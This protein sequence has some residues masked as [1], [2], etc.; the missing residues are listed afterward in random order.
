[1]H[2]TIPNFVLCCTANTLK[3]AFQKSLLLAISS[4]LYLSHYVC[5]NKEYSSQTGVELVVKK[6][7]KA[8]VG[9]CIY[10]WLVGKENVLV[11]LV[12]AAPALTEPLKEEWSSH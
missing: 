2:L 8:S 10:Y 3:I 7:G 9:C 4:S 11:A 6:Q 1:M 12:P 5:Q